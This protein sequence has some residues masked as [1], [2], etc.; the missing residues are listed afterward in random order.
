MPF[1]AHVKATA[2]DLGL[3]AIRSR[4]IT[5]LGS[6]LHHLPSCFSDDDDDDST[7]NGSVVRSLSR[8]YYARAQPL[9]A[10]R[11]RVAI[12]DDDDSVREMQVYRHP[13][14]P[15]LS[16]STTEERVGEEEEEERWVARNRDPYRDEEYLSYSST[17]WGESRNRADADGGAGGRGEGSDVVVVVVDD[18]AAA[19]AAAAAGEEER[20]RRRRRRVATATAAAIREHDAEQ[21]ERWLGGG[22]RDFGFSAVVA[23]AGG[24]RRNAISVAREPGAA[25]GN[26][27]SDDDDGRGDA[28]TLKPLPRRRSGASVRDPQRRNARIWDEE[29]N[30]IL[31]SALENATAISPHLSGAELERRGP[32]PAP[33]PLPTASY[34]RTDTSLYRGLYGEQ[35]RRR[36]P[37]PSCPPPRGEPN[38]RIQAR[39]YDRRQNAHRAE[40]LIRRPVDGAS[41]STTSVKADERPQRQETG[42]LTD[43]EFPARLTRDGPGS[44]LPSHLVVRPITSVT[45]RRPVPVPSVVRTS[46]TDALDTHSHEEEAAAWRGNGEVEG[47]SSSSAGGGDRDGSRRGSSSSSSTRR[48]T[49]RSSR[50]STPTTTTKTSVD[51]EWLRLTVRT[52][53]WV[54]FPGAWAGKWAEGSE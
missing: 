36:L 23:T 20:R 21:L 3:G 1:I 48:E 16:S 18:D 4:A 22:E 17:S 54:P 28:A 41:S 52:A 42:I 25:G 6:R 39:I 32:P 51:E 14:P 46:P 35:Q 50:S 37:R 26:G 15:P 47:R 45:R 9:R 13:P 38:A 44:R 49:S 40:A 5:T 2:H 12:D 24:G 11:T 30:I 31:F 34:E 10:R 43:Q 27:R 8:A 53:E 19:A 29:D 7:V 33:A